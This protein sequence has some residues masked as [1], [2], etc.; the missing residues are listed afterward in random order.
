MMITEEE[1]KNDGSPSIAEGHNKYP[2]GLRLNL[3]S[4]TLKK[5]GI[6]KPPQVN[7]KMKI[8]AM[9]EVIEVS[10]DA[11]PGDVPEYRVEL[12]ITELGVAEKQPEKK[13]STEVFYGE[14]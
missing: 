2:Y 9:V 11:K 10:S 12:Q 8:E 14:N 4:K 7:T 3:C 6:A 5:M 1:R 13:E